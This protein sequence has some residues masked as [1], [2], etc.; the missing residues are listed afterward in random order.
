MIES[1]PKQNIV[2]KWLRWHFI[3]ESKTI[4]KAWRNFLYFNFNYFSISQLLKTFF[5]HWRRYRD[6]Y[7]RGFDIKRYIQVFISNTISRVLGVIVRTITILIGLTVEFFIFVGGIFVFLFWVLLPVI[8]I[9]LFLLGLQ[10]LSF[11]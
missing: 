3:E 11:I 4:F 6:F 8:V 2:F 5:S 10:F 7:G 9:I 1:S